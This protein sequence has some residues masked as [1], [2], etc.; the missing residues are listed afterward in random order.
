MNMN[1]DESLDE[2]RAIRDCQYEE[3]KNM[4][5]EEL[6]EHL[7]KEAEPVRKEVERLRTE[8]LAKEQFNKAS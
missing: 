6:L 1:H 5:R 2:I 3:T 7:R 8:R 4:A